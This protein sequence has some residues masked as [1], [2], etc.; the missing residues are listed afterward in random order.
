MVKL[1]DCIM[2]KDGDIWIWPFLFK[3][4]I[5]YL[6]LNQNHTK[7]KGTGLLYQKQHL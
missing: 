4:E 3:W 5:S 7:H 6:Y 2:F 1:P